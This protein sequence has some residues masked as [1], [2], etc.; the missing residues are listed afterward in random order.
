MARGTPF[1]AGVMV[2]IILVLVLQGCS[3]THSHQCSSSCGGIHN[4]KY[5]FRLIHDPPNC[6]DQRYHLS[7][8][9]NQTMLYL[10]AGK[11]NVQKINYTDSSIHVVDSRIS[12]DSYSSTPNCSLDHF[13]YYSKA[14]GPYTPFPK[15]G[16]SLV[17]CENPMNSSFDLNISSCFDDE[18][19]SSKRR[20]GYILSGQMM[21]S[22]LEE[23][24]QVE[25]T[26]LASTWQ[27]VMSQVDKN[28]S[29]TD[30]HDMLLYGFELSWYFGSCGSKY[31]SVNCSPN[32]TENQCWCVESIG[33]YALY[34]AALA[35]GAQFAL[36]IVFG[37]PCV[38]LLLIYKWRKRHFSVYDAI[39]EFL[40]SHNNLRPIRYSYKKFKKMTNNF[41]DKLGEGGYG[42]VFKGTLRSGQLVAVKMLGKAKANGQEF[43]NEVATIGRIHHVNIVQLVGFCVKGAERALVYEFMPKGSLNKYIFSQE[44]GIFLSYEKLYDIALGVAHGIEYL[45][46]G[47]DMQILHFDIKPHNILLDDNFTPKVSDFGLAKLYAVNDSIVSLTAVRGTLGYMAPELFYKNIGGL[48]YKADVYS[49][50]ML[51]ME[52]ASRRKN[53][54][55]SVDHSSQV[56]FPTWIYD[57]LQDGRDIEIDNVTEEEREICKKMIIVALWCIQMKPSYR[58][59][60]HEVVGMLEEN[61]NAYKCLPNLS[62]RHQKDPLKMLETAQLGHQ[63]H[64]GNLSLSTKC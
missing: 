63:L 17:S 27:L 45:H 19:Y 1:P 37:T 28:A 35:M 51:L 49:F 46:R 61:W 62:Y 36:K 57:Q 2:F 14:W 56:Y 21:A 33:I 54:N 48:S 16:F 26:C 4:I 24:C 15:D 25:H 11:Y 8:E 5:P 47:C 18:A 29:C 59:S 64:Q 60:M 13:G 41:K 53:V 30:I 3:V 7:C 31:G 6:G 52:M 9:N 20:H 40:Q 22:D 39:E 55:A 44:E 12:K 10:S 43:I 34:A 23:L 38:I 58:P 50:G 32:G 42:T